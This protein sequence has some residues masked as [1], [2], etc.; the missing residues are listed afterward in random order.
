[1][2]TAETETELGAEIWRETAVRISK[3]GI[4]RAHALLRQQAIAPF[5]GRT[6]APVKARGDATHWIDAEMRKSMRVFVEE[7]TGGKAIYVGEEENVPHNLTHRDILARTDE[8]DGTTNCLT[9]FS[10]FAIVVFIERVRR[11][12]ESVSHVAGAIA[13]ATGEVTSW[14][15]DQHGEGKVMIEW[16]TS[17]SW[18]G[19]D[20]GQADVV[21][22]VPF[23][24]ELNKDP[25]AEPSPALR[26]G[27]PNRIAVNAAHASRRTLLNGAMG[28]AL[29]EDA[30]LWVANHAGNPLVAPLLGGEL[31]AIYEP[32][33]LQLH[34]A[35]YLIP[36]YLAGGKIRS[37]EGAYVDVL[38]HF[39]ELGSSRTIGPF[40]AGTSKAAVDRVISAL[41]E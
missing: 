27:L 26:P 22:A 38:G 39:E 41:N 16:P 21:P 24:L 23:Q 10:A 7:V 8:L 12:E 34:D 15:R 37:P 5:K 33:A 31:S 6:E 30:E 36:L 40:I 35:A 25:D 28:K 29:A 17:F 13:A 11:Q 20:G 19:E 18:G 14:S 2:N 9:L 4:N 3:R 1:M 32:K